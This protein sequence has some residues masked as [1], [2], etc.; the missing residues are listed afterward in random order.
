MSD[1]ARGDAIADRRFPRDDHLVAGLDI[2]TTKTRCAIAALQPGSSPVIVGFGCVA[3]LG[4]QKGS[5]RDIAAAARCIREA[6]DK[7]SAQA[8][9]EIQAV[10]LAISGKHLRSFNTRGVGTITH[11]ERLI[12]AADRDRVLDQSRLVTLAAGEE[13]VHAIPR[14]YVVDGVGGI[15]QPVGMYGNA[16]EVETNILVGAQTTLRNVEQAVDRAGL[17][18]AEKVLAPLAAG[19]ALLKQEERENG[20]CVVDIGA[21][22]TELA[23][24][25]GCEILHAKIWEVGGG[26]ITN[27]LAQLL[28]VNVQE[29]ER[30]KI[31]AGSAL[32]AGVGAEEVVEIWQIGRDSPRQLL[33]QA[34]CTIIE[35]RVKEIFGLIKKELNDQG[36]LDKIT[37]G[38]VL[39]GGTAL[40][41]G[42]AV[43]AHEVLGL[44]V[45]VSSPSGLG[46]RIPVGGVAPGGAPP[47]N[48]NP[49]LAVV[50]GVVARVAAMMEA[51][52]DEE[53]E[54]FFD[55]IRRWL[56]G[57]RRRR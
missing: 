19:H 37:N 22:T 32:P 16:L 39:T 54:S 15:R 18:V 46:V 44:P 52:P 25:T 17:V 11:P 51:E 20:V 24:F 49:D 55:A 47:G 35:A 6:V 14:M 43:C 31:V 1:M 12:Q 29:A 50:V 33:R 7:A 42:I 34:V 48:D 53:D 56:L 57:F 27:D 38:V 3:T 41:P 10:H 4:A 21:G 23:V 28:E 8:G 40:L 26:H 2:G 45:R 13:I 9:E 5:I 36:L 30:I